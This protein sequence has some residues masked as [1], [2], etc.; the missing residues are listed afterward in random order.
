MQMIRDRSPVENRLERPRSGLVFTDNRPSRAEA[1]TAINEA[2]R[3]AR[4]RLA[5]RGLGAQALS[6]G[7][8]ARPDSRHNAT[9]CW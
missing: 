2:L 5:A 7:D 3:T 8:M 9:R 1:L 6:A 4:D